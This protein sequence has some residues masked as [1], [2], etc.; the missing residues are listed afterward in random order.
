ML[1]VDEQDHWIRQACRKAVNHQLGFWVVVTL[2][3]ASIVAYNGRFW[4]NFFAGPYVV[5]SAQLATMTD[6]SKER[7]EFVSVT[8]NKLYETGVKQMTT[9]THNGVAG[10]TYASADY[11][12]LLMDGKLLLIKSTKKPGLTLAGQLQ[13]VDDSLVHTLFDDSPRAQAVRPA[14]L[15]VY[16][17]TA[18][19]RTSGYVSLVALALYVW[20]LWF[21]GARAWR[22]RRNI[23]LHPV[24][25]AVEEW[26]AAS[27][28]IEQ[29]QQERTGAVR[30]T[31]RG[32]TVTDGYLIS[33]GFFSFKIFRIDTLLWAYQKVTK[34]SVNL[35]P[36]GKTDEAMLKFT[37][38]EFAVQGSEAKVLELLRYLSQRV[39]W[40]VM[41]FTP[42][43]D[44]FYKKDAA[45]FAQAVQE[46]R[47]Q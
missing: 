44:Q 14:L 31:S 19:Y 39:P 35:I 9:E 21:F 2:G 20:I 24:V 10:R 29:A 32:T 22:Y 33:Q 47:Q 28:A 40:V 5:Q 15:P 12:A 6:L 30:F 45:G 13:P 36:A 34:K 25:R 37:G 26:P 27:K 17:D 42:E 41:G 23:A 1:P 16:V 4:R 7:R 38:G 11:Y 18:S 43:L 3:I 8:G 46:R